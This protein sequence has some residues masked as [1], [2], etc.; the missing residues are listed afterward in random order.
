[1]T[2]GIPR[3]FAPQSDPRPDAARLQVRLYA[4][5]RDDGTWDALVVD[6]VAYQVALEL[7]GESDD[8]VVSRLVRAAL[9]F[10]PD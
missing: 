2:T 7:P 5:N 1:M 10:R 6:E 9:G 4:R 8:D 3:R